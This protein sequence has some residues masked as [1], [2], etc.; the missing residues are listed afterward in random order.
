MILKINGDKVDFTLEKEAVLS[1]VVD[2]VKTWLSTSGYQV[3]GIAVGA[4]NLLAAPR[5]RWAAVPISSVAEIDFSASR[6]EEIRIEHWATARAWLG[7]LAQA[8]SARSLEALHELVSEIPSMFQG[9]KKNPFLPAGSEAVDRL[10]ALFA[11]QT[12]D[13]IRSWPAG[14]LNAAVEGISALRAELARR[15]SEATHPAQTLKTCLEEL[16][17]MIGGISEV[18]LFLQTG[19]DKLAMDRVI[20]FSGAL[21]RLLDILPFLPKDSERDGLFQ[22]IN[23]VLK[24]ILEAFDSKDLVLIGDLF[25]Y[26]VAPRL[27]RLLPALERCL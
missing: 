25:E 23:Q 6:S 5:D 7:A 13:A 18:S 2:G 14:Q 10:A 22:E 3:T 4:E 9:L 15:I 8:V 21:Q 16:R 11:G 24:Q 20:R 1:E 26:E 19:K 12:P 17:P 27:T